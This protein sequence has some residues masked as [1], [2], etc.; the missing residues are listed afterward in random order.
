MPAGDLIPVLADPHRSFHAY[1][2]LL[3]LG[4]LAATAAR[5]GLAHPDARVREYC[6]QLLDHLLDAES[7]PALVHALGD[8]S[9]RVRT[10]AVHALACDRC[11]ADASRPAAEAVLPA[12]IAVLGSDPSARVRAYAAELVGRW[13]HSQAAA[14]DA[15]ARAAAADPSP[16]VRKK[17]SWYAPGGPIY[18]RTAPGSQRRGPRPAA[19]GVRG[20]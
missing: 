7:V 11:K 2:R 15:I 14:R 13:V 9:A 18:R 4:P 17:A 5:G 1:T 8:P 3:A 20:L 19:G 16:A 6:C 12:A 10:Q